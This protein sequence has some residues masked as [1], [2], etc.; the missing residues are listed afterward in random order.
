MTAQTMQDLFSTT[1][2]QWLEGA[3]HAARQLLRR[4][5]NITIEDVLDIYP[6][7]KYLHRNVTGRVFQGTMFSPVGYTSAKKLSS[8]GRV[9]RVWAFSD[10]YSNEAESDCE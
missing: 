5:A 4:K 9:I 2:E 1:R 3:R 6:R 7:P 10:A 8:H